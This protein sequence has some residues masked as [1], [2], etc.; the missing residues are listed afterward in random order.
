MVQIWN[1]SRLVNS[2]KTRSL[3]SQL[4]LAGLNEGIYM[5]RAIV[6]GKAYSGKFIKDK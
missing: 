6:D 5:V 4:S 1:G 2:I 3:V